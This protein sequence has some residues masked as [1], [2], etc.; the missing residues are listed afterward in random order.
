LLE[1]LPSLFEYIIGLVTRHRRCD[2]MAVVIYHLLGD[3]ANAAEN[4]LTR[5]LPATLNEPYLQKPNH[6]T[7]YIGWA[8]F[9]NRDFEMVD[10]CLQRL[11]HAAW[12]LYMDAAWRMMANKNV[13]RAGFR[14]ISI[15]DTY[16]WFDVFNADYVCC[17]VKP[18]EPVL[19]VSAVN[20]ESWLNA[21][22]ERR[23][24]NR[25]SGPPLHGIEERPPVVTKSTWSISD[26][27][28]VS[29]LQAVGLTRLNEM[30][31]TTHRFASWLTAN[32]T[33][34]QLL[35]PHQ[36]TLSDQERSCHRPDSAR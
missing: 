13:D 11:E 33:L 36:G 7:P 30:R 2:S 4:A 31:E 20:I 17:V 24:K 21:A 14:P 10:R 18:F 19:T 26:R 32:C 6:G 29:E 5:H 22:A 8:H 27:A 35:A 28:T 23:V 16:V 15:K 12:K 3:V 9:T 25:S 34:E 1:G